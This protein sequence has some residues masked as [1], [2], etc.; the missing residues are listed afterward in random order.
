MRAQRGEV[1]NTIDGE[2]GAESGGIE[3]RLW[4]SWDLVVEE[5]WKRMQDEY[6]EGKFLFCPNLLSHIEQSTLWS[7][8]TIEDIPTS[9]IIRVYDLSSYDVVPSI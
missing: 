7:I 6:E 5:V 3:R 2:Q 8:T 9:Y 1:H 4:S